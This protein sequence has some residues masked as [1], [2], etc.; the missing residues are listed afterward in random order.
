MMHDGPSIAEPPCFPDVTKFE[1]AECASLRTCGTANSA[2]L[3]ALAQPS[4]ASL[5]RHLEIRHRMTPSGRLRP[6][7]NGA[8]NVESFLQ[9]N[10]YDIAEPSPNVAFP[11]G[12]LVRHGGLIQQHRARHW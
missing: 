11:A 10:S 9:E 4:A 3:V 6:H 12:G 8:G 7:A 1:L 2:F 5:G